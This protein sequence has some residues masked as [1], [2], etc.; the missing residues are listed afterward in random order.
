MPKMH[1]N[2]FG[3]LA[4]PGPAGGES[5]GTEKSSLLQICPLPQNLTLDP[6]LPTS[7]LEANVRTLWWVSM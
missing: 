1:Q 7:F 5:N 2:M 4:S 6:P 3:G